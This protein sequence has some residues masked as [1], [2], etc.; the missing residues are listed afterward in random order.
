MQAWRKRT[1]HERAATE[2]FARRDVGGTLQ[3]SRLRQES[4]SRVD[5]AERASL[6]AR[7]VDANAARRRGAALAAK[8]L[9]QRASP[10]APGPQLRPG[11][12]RVGAGGAGGIEGGL[13]RGPERRRRRPLGVP[14]AR[15][16]RVGGRRGRRRRRAL[17]VALRGPGAG[18]PAPTSVPTAPTPPPELLAKQEADRVRRDA[19]ALCDQRRWSAR[20]AELRRADALDPARRRVAELSIRLEAKMG[21]AAT[22][23]IGRQ[24]GGALRRVRSR[25]S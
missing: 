17:Y 25:R 20:L 24:A 15:G 12:A 5:R 9:A 7:G 23:R 4:A 14:A 2:A 10:A 18:P 16:G 3:K 6:E 19:M 8:L 21:R 11:R 13:P 22:R 1:G